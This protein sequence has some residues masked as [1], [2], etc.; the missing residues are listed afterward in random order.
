MYKQRA[1]VKRDMS[2]STGVHDIVVLACSSL[3]STRDLQRLEA[4]TRSPIFTQFSETL[5]GLS[6][7]RAFG[8]TAQFEKASVALVA[9]N[10]QCFY[11]QDTASTLPLVA[12]SWGEAARQVSRVTL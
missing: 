9:A 6:T 1:T 4:V 8:R 3:A 10:T 2:R 11:N 12:A 7:I 5:S